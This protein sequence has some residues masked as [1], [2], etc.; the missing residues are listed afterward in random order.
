MGTVQSDGTLN[1][2]TVAP[3]DHMIEIRKDQF[4][5]ETD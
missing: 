3:G 5:A 4:K 2:A 1:L